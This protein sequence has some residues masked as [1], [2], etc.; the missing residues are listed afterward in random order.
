M[1][2]VPKIIWQTHEWGYEDL[3]DNFKRAAMTWQN[4][5]PGWEYRYVTAAERKEQIRSNPEHALLYLFYLAT[6]KVTQADIWRYIT[7]YEHGGAYADMDSACAEPL[8]Y[9]LRDVQPGTEIVCT[10]P[11]QNGDINNANFVATRLSRVLYAVLE[12]IL[13]NIYMKVSLI[14][15]LSTADNPELSLEEALK[16]NLGLG[17]GAYSDVLKQFESIVYKNYRGALHL[18]DMKKDDYRPKHVVNYYGN[19]F[20][21]VYLAEKNNWS[22]T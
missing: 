4:L 15:V 7:L 1:L 3:P 16:M 20:S 9:S 19:L 6:D 12:N 14:S 11:D 8:D 5:N 21:Y 2:E 18:P 17:P 10:P 22:L 13:S